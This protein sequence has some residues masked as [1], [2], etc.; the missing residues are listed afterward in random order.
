M[1]LYG[2]APE[3][4][5]YGPIAEANEALGKEQLQIMRTQLRWSRQQTAKMNETI[6]KVVG[7]ALETDKQNREFGKEQ[8]ERYKKVYQPLEDK[9]A[10]EAQEYDTEAR[11][12]QEAGRAIS[13]VGQAFDADRASAE[14]RLQGYGID[15]SMM[16]AGSLDASARMAEAEAKAGAGTNARRRVEDVG[17]SLRADVI[18]MGRGLPSQ[19]A[20]AYGTSLAAGQGA[21]NQAQ[22]G[23][24]T[25]SNA[26][27][28]PAVWGQGAQGAYGNA[29][30][31]R[32]AGYQNALAGYE[33]NAQYGAWG[34]ISDF[35]A[36]A[37]GTAMGSFMEKGG[38]VEP[39]MSPS[40]GAIPDDVPARL[41]AGEHVIPEDVVRWKGEEFFEKLKMGARK[42]KAE[43]S[44]AIPAQGAA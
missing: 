12:E 9:F 32:N 17:R 30:T 11:R 31:A 34:Q 44:G 7:S 28:A 10:K 26:G 27:T 8:Q 43:A 24:Q 29:I 41:T 35:A 36:T 4:P 20:A 15:P 3:P 6:D 14:R 38:P 19:A 42:A 22:G 2:E 40:G 16:R 13:D 25:G 5:D 1:G 18:N 23:L 39:G 33:A 21:G 37:A